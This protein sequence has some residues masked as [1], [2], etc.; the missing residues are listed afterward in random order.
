LRQVFLNLIINAAHAISAGGKTAGGKLL[1]KS[2]LDGETPQRES[3]D[4]QDRQ[5]DAGAI[6]NSAGLGTPGQKT[7]LQNRITYLKILFIDNGPGIPEENISN[8]FDPFFTT[9]E[10]GKGTGLGLSVSYM[11]VEGF[12]GQM[13]VESKIGQGTTMTLRLPVCEAEV[14]AV[15]NGNPFEIKKYSGFR[16]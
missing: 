5:M 12:G 8:I 11:I 9:K 6:E 14:D 2:V 3:D 1:I 4:A 15:T 10:P 16:Q 13:S 7:Q